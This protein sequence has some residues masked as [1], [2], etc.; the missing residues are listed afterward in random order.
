[1]ESI[2]NGVPVWS[3]SNLA[4]LYGVS[5]DFMPGVVMQEGNRHPLVSSWSTMRTRHRTPN[6]ET[7]IPNPEHNAQPLFVGTPEGRMFHLTSK[8]R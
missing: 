4:Y 8:L 6:P 5:P 1:M 7:R 3:F 2:T